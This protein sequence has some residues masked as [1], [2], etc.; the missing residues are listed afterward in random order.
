MQAPK[1]AV[2]IAAAAALTV[3]VLLDWRSQQ[4]TTTQMQ[5]LAAE[6]GLDQRRAHLTERIASEPDPSRARLVLARSILSDLLDPSSR[7]PENPAA[8]SVEDQLAAPERATELARAEEQARPLAWR[9]SL[10]KGA[11]IYLERSL[12]RDERLVREAREWEAPLERA[13]T[14]GPN[15]SDPQRFVA[16]AY[17]ELWP[18]LSETKQNVARGLL[19]N[20]FQDQAAFRQ[21]SESWLRIVDPSPETLDELPDAA[22][23]WQQLMIVSSRSQDWPLF[24]DSATRL[25]RVNE[26]ALA[27]QLE[28][29]LAALARG[30]FSEARGQLQSALGTP[31][32]RS[33]ASSVERALTRMPAGPLH[34]SLRHSAEAWVDFTLQQCLYRGCPLSPGV[35]ERISRQLGDLGAERTQQIQVVLAGRPSSGDS[36]WNP[37]VTEALTEPLA[38]LQAARVADRREQPEIAATIA[39]RAPKT[40]GH[41]LLELELQGLAPAADTVGDWRSTEPARFAAEVRL[42]DVSKTLR[43]PFSQIDDRGAAVEAIWDGASL[44]IFHVTR[45][46]PELTLAVD[47]AG[48]TSLLEIRLRG[49][50]AR[51]GR[52]LVS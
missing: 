4:R 45:A 3:A 42:I 20:V 40:S 5:A 18:F 7:S 19:H 46:R 28:T 50:R 1:R 41:R 31:P 29:G 25:A 10:V 16:M 44:G 22:H 2:L 38:W 34:R 24:I 17:L 12:T 8:T 6:L 48:T 21:L 13:L 52:V 43:I 35:V 51:P 37:L 39:Q 27:A 33:S 26:R 47:V 9:A 23:I 32:S 30:D 14:L 11:A 49:G 36:S 15:E